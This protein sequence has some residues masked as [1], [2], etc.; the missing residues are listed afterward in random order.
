MTTLVRSLLVAILCITATVLWAAPNRPP[1]NVVVATVT[2]GTL[3]PE[4]TFI[5]TVYYPEVSDVSAQ[6]SGTVETVTFEE[7]RF[8]S[9]GDPLVRMDSSL[10]NKTLQSKMASYEQVLSD[11]ERA[12]KYLARTKNLYQRKIVAEKTYDD[13]RFTVRSLQKKAASLKAEA[14]RLEIELEKTI[15]RAPFNG[16]VIKKG[17]SPG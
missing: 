14:E 1:A 10:L 5:G 2:R 16:I 6:V 11:L 4:K 13:Q 9:K 8:V 17:T 3:A 7:G 12:S 15:I